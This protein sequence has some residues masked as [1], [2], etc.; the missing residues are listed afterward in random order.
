MYRV[1]EA[2]GWEPPDWIVVP[3]GNLG[4]SSA[5]GK[6]FIE[7]HELGL[8]DRVPRIAVINSTGARTLYEFVEEGMTVVLSSPNM[9]EAA[10]CHRV[11][12][13][14]DGSLLTEG[15]PAD[16]T[17]R[18]VHPTLLLHLGGRDQV[19]DLIQNREEVLS[20][21]PEGSAIRAVV[22]RDGEAA[23]LEW[24]EGHA[25]TARVERVVPTFEDVFLSLLVDK[26]AIGDGVAS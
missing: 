8:I 25:F 4:N 18:L 5:F 13:L 14:A 17:A 20:V 7:L 3:G 19:E 9:D 16:L 10:R 6:A 24:A 11:G 21:S 1:L 22:H 2:L 23:F 26:S 12:L 15:E